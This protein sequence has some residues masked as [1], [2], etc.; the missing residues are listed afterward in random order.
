[1]AGKNLKNLTM[2]TIK[3]SRGRT[4]GRNRGYS[5]KKNSKPGF[6]IIGE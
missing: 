4:R 5:S 2:K 1:M 3:T 6:L